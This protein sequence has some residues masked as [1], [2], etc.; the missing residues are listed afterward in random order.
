MKI[1]ANNAAFGGVT[2]GPC[3]DELNERGSFEPTTNLNHH[4]IS[5]TNHCSAHFLPLTFATR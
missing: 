3:P 5:N 1:I 4:L 2:E